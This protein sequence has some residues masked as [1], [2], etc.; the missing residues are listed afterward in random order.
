M[1]KL[2]Q[3]FKSFC[4]VAQ[5]EGEAALQPTTW[6]RAYSKDFTLQ[7]MHSLQLWLC[8]IRKCTQSWQW[9]MLL[10][11][12]L[13]RHVACALHKFCN[14]PWHVNQCCECNKRCSKHNCCMISIAAARTI[15][16]NPLT[17]YLLNNW[18]RKT[19]FIQ[20]RKIKAES[21]TGDTRIT[22][23]LAPV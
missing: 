16:F 22:T 18:N 4:E 8:E 7:F 14:S 20:C 12:K 13:S 6:P 23:G 2:F 10:N 9:Y 5:S 3:M 21:C 19:A 15:Y 11:A 17:Y 1:F